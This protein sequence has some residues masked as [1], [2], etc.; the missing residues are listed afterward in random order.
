MSDGKIIFEVNLSF[1]LV[2]ATVA[3][4]DTGSLKF[5]HALFNTYLNHTPGK[6]KPNRMVRNE[7][8][9]ALND[10]SPSFLKT[11]LTER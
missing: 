1:K 10:K 5:I 7:K 8:Q 11:V 4:S 2:R 6:I 9:I 3:T